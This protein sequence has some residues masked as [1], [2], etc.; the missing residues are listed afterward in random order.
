M[1]VFFFFFFLFNSSDLKRAEHRTEVFWLQINHPVTLVYIISHLLCVFNSNMKTQRQATEGRSVLDTFLLEII[2]HPWFS[3]HSRQKTYLV[4]PSLNPQRL[5][6]LF[7]VRKLFKPLPTSNGQMQLRYL[8]RSWR[9]SVFSFG[10]AWQE[11]AKQQ[12]QT[13]GDW[14]MEYFC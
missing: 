14:M 6:A 5:K 8:R 3:G 2:N 10:L 11:L 7:R 12:K 13:S 9:G 1:K 4:S